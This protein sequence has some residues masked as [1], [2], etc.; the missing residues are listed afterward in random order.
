MR[1]SKIEIIKEYM[2][3]YTC[4]IISGETGDVIDYQT[5]EEAYSTY[6]KAQVRA[7]ELRKL[8][9]EEICYWGND[10]GIL[11]EVD[12]DDEPTENIYAI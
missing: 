7:E 1:N 12:V 6:N 10:V 4:E 11:R 2:V 9:G 3:Y 8:I 5:E